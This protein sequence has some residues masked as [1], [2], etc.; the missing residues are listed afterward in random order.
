MKKI[1]STFMIVLVVIFQAFPA[2]AAEKVIDRNSETPIHLDF[3]NIRL[4]QSGLTIDSSGK[5]NC[6]GRSILYSNSNSSQMSV[7]LQKYSGGYWSTVKSWSKTVYGSTPANLVNSYYVVNGTYR[8][9]CTV[10]VYN[11]SGTLL[12]TRT[13]YSATQTY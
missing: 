13:A 1:I 10:R 12:E 6:T 2:F 7:Q 8:V 9:S 5:A 4:L 11:A 3:V